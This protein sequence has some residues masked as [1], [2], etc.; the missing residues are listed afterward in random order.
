MMTAGLD[1]LVA[2]FIIY[3]HGVAPNAPR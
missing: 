3:Q 1:T 2:N